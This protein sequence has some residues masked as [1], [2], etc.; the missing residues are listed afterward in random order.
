LAGSPVK[1]RSIVVG[2]TGSIAAYKAAEVVSQLAQRGA[3]VTP[4]LTRG[5]Q[6]F[7]T[8]LTLQTLSG[9]RALTQ[10]FDEERVEDPTHI[11]LARQTELLLIAPATAN[12]LGKMAAGIAD[13]LLTSFVLAV[14]CP[15][16][17]APAMNT[18]MWTHA[19]VQANVAELQGRGV[20]FIEPEEGRLACGDVGAG[21][22][23]EPARI[24]EAVES[25]FL[26]T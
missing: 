15:V 21:R 2:V 11:G 18:Q 16:L 6:R 22:L 19:A 5:A 24:V 17:V 13:D 26:R 14:R 8:A 1:D 12:V 3:R 9:R 25:L 10:T 7:I 20:K 4:I 23:V